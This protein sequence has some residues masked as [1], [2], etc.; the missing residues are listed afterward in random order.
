MSSRPSFERTHG[1]V[2]L[3]LSVWFATLFTIGFTAIFALL[4]WLLA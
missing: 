2:A 1:S 4:Y 3:R